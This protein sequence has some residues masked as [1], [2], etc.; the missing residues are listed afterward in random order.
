MVAVELDGDLCAGRHGGRADR[1]LAHLDVLEH[2]LQLADPDLL[3]TLLLARGVVAAVLA[4][5]AL[6]AGLGD[7]CR[8]LRPALR[9]EVLKFGGEAIERLLSQPGDR[10]SVMVAGYPTSVSPPTA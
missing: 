7:L 10:R 9:L 8:H 2:R 1:G 5:V 3:L 4:E 6:L